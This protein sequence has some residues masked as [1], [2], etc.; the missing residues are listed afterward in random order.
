[1]AND[2]YGG[3][4][5][6]AD[7]VRVQL[8]P[9][10]PPG[11]TLSASGE[12]RVLART[13]AGSYQLS[14]SVCLVSA[15]TDCATASATVRVDVANVSFLPDGVQ[16]DQ[17][18]VEAFH[19]WKPNVPPKL[20][21]RRPSDG[22]DA[23]GAYGLSNTT[24]DALFS[25]VYPMST[26]SAEAIN[27]VQFWRERLRLLQA[28]HPDWDP[29]TLLAARNTLAQRIAAYERD[30]PQQ[31]AQSA[32]AFWGTMTAAPD[33]KTKAQVDLLSS[34]I[35]AL[36]AR[37]SNAEAPGPT[38][39]V[40]RAPAELYDELTRLSAQRAELDGSA[41]RGVIAAGMV[42]GLVNL[43]ERG[44]VNFTYEDRSL[45]EIIAS[46][47]VDS[48]GQVAEASAR[49]NSD[50]Q[51]QHPANGFG[52]VSLAPDFRLQALAAA[53][54]GP[55]GSGTYAALALTGDTSFFGSSGN[56]LPGV[57]EL[58]SALGNRLFPRSTGAATPASQPAVTLWS[59]VPELR[60]A[61]RRGSGGDGD[62]A[63]PRGEWL[64]GINAAQARRLQRERSTGGPGSALP[65]LGIRLG[66]EGVSDFSE[67]V[68]AAHLGLSLTQASFQ[69]ALAAGSPV[70]DVL[71]AAQPRAFGWAPQQTVQVGD[72][73]KKQWNRD[74]FQ[75]ER[76]TE[77]LRQ[78]TQTEEGRAQLV[79]I[80][81]AQLAKRRV[82]PG[83][84]RETNLLT[85]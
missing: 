64:A 77:R 10:A 60:P 68:G 8:G 18:T 48:A 65:Q 42:N 45:V 73:V 17:A 63:D 49:L 19:W 22:L 44:D 43:L 85:D 12:L 23:L 32:E 25:D 3:Q 62:R 52:G 26:V 11:L 30:I 13:P 31:F 33:A 41:R 16:M 2:R 15:P 61:E 7:S 39:I 59:D 57:A 9:D 14:Y 70:S 37:I 83:L 50:W 67:A 81:T 55:A 80:V 56:P 76:I 79:A 1:M 34:Q 40:Q 35:D 53:G 6:V 21:E 78:L 27:A 24:L 58:A 4:P 5:L 54:L 51:K 84:F 29:P 69:N 72:N 74:L 20:T 46:M 28:E 36:L 82:D 71:V 66:T 75:P 47:V 38:G